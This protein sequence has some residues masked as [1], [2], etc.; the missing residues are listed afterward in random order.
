PRLTPARAGNAMTHSMSLGR[1]WAHPR[2]RGEYSAAVIPQSLGGSP[3]LARGIHLR[4]A[5]PAV[6]RRLTPARAGNTASVTTLRVARPAHP[7]SCGEYIEAFT[8]AADT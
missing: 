4:H 5:A 7:R 2:L 8:D 6:G 3:P 1:Q